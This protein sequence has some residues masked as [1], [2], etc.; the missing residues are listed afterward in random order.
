MVVNHSKCN[1]KV[2]PGNLGASGYIHVSTGIK[3]VW[4][5]VQSQGH[6][7]GEVLVVSSNRGS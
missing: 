5:R 7:E 4:P 3:R 6:Q 2:P 1:K